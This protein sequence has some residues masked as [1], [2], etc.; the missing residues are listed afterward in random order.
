M[1]NRLAATHA[2][3]HAR[4]AHL[5]WDEP[6]RRLQVEQTYGRE[7]LDLLLRRIDKHLAHAAMLALTHGAP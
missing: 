2:S 7:V 4:V 1:I 3:G 6:D 5:Q